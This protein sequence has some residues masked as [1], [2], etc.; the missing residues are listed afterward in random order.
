MNLMNAT[1]A[2]H[3]QRGPLEFFMLFLFD[4]VTNN[5]YP[6]IQ[7]FGIPKWQPALAKPLLRNQ[8]WEPAPVKQPDLDPKI[9]CLRWQNLTFLSKMN[10][11]AGKTAILDPKVSSCARKTIL[12]GSSMNAHTGNNDFG[13]W[14]ESVKAKRQFGIQKWDIQGFGVSKWVLPPAKLTPGIQKWKPARFRC[15]RECLKQK[16]R[17]RGPR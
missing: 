17:L 13:C 14:S 1:L 5:L 7:P 10:A 8:M 2:S 6:S 3:S 4:A 12:W 9:E 15:K 16:K 11:H